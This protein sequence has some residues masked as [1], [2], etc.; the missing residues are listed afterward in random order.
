MPQ[1]LTA[2]TPDEGNAWETWPAVT[3][4]DQLN[5]FPSLSSWA[6]SSVY[7]VYNWNK[8][9]LT[10]PGGYNPLIDSLTLTV[11]FIPSK[12]SFSNTFFVAG[13]G[14]A[15]SGNLI[16]CRFQNLT[17]ITYSIQF[18]AFTDATLTG[19]I[20]SASSEC[21]SIANDATA[22][23]VLTFSPSALNLTAQLTASPTNL[24][25]VETNPTPLTMN[26]LFVA[27]LADSASNLVKLTSV[28]LEVAP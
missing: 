18:F 15:A 14:D 2:H 1:A 13:L 27:T 8:T 19:N 10:F 28:T 24:N 20:G 12:T 21:A 25:V 9:A 11:T 23:L 16:G 17:T 6:A 7:S 5:V 26:S 3:P 22:T 4:V